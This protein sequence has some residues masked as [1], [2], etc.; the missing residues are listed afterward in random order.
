MRRLF[1]TILILLTTLLCG[2]RHMSQEADGKTWYITLNQLSDNETTINYD[3]QELQTD[4]GEFNIQNRNTF[5][6]YVYLYSDSAD[7]V[8]ESEI[9]VGGMCSFRQIE[10]E[11]TYTIGVHADVDEGTDILLAVYDSDAAAEPYQTGTAAPFE[12]ESDDS[13]IQSDGTTLETRIN[14]PDSY[15]RTESEVNDFSSFVRNYPLKEDGSSVL[16]YDGRKKGNQNAHIAVFDLPLEEEDL[17]QCA[18]SVMRMYAEYFW[19]TGQSDKIMFHFTNGFEA[20][21]SKWRDGY[22]ISVDRNDVSWVKSAEYDDS[23][24]TFVKYLRIV[25]SYA[26]TLSMEATESTATS[27]DTAQIGDVFLKGASPGHVVMIVDVCENANG[28]KAFLLAQGYMPAQEFHVLKNPAHPDDPWYYEEE[29]TY[30]LDTPEY[31]FEERSLKRLDY[32]KD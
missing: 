23:Y 21:Y 15:E 19:E 3:D 22:R 28:E 30:P 17:Q 7:L 5:P 6:V 31:T 10:P 32:L 25:F 24:G 1:Y 13:M 9:Q 14:T 8:H 4:T 16:L 11:T 26:G 12:K 18:D 20:Y 2:C 27:L 29:I